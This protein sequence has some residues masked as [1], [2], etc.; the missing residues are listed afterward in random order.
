MKKERFIKRRE[1]TDCDLCC[2][3]GKQTCDT[4]ECKGGYYVAAK[5][6]R[7]GKYERLL[8]RVISPIM[9]WDMIESVKG[10]WISE[11]QFAELKEIKERMK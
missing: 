1:I 9:V 5:P 6:K 7:A 4:N 11:K 10:E 2:R 8:K 3:A